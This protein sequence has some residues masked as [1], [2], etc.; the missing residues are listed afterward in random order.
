MSRRLIKVVWDGDQHSYRLARR[1]GLLIIVLYLLFPSL[2]V[3][4]AILLV[5]QAFRRRFLFEE[6]DENDLDIQP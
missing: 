2:C 3:V 1:C 6:V 4:P 5:F